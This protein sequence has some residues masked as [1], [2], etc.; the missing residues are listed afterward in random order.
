MEEEKG[1][2]ASSGGLI[3]G[4]PPRDGLFDCDIKDC[5]FYDKCVVCG[6]CSEVVV[7]PDTNNN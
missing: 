5:V 3:C 4:G 7:V 2:I 1:Q 6:W